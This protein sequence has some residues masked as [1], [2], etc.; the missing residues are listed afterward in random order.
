MKNNVEFLTVDGMRICFVNNESYYNF[1]DLCEYA[2]KLNAEKEHPRGIPVTAIAKE[3]GM[4]GVKLN[5]YL[6]GKH[7]QYKCKGVWHINS[8]YGKKGY[9]VSVSARNKKTHMYW[10]YEGKM[11]IEKLLEEDGYHKVK[12]D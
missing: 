3:Y 1:G 2:K 6:C 4:S 5:E 10:T 8:K 12:A 11:F 7:I 9:V